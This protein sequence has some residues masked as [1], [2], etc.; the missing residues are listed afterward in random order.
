MLIATFTFLHIFD[1]IQLE[2][3]ISILAKFYFVLKTH[4]VLRLGGVARVVG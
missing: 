4:S 1:I 2:L 3:R